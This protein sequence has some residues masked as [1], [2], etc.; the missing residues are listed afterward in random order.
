[1]NN[2]C[3]IIILVFI[4]IVNRKYLS[5][6]KYN[7]QQILQITSTFDKRINEE[8]HILSYNFKINKTIK[9]IRKY[10]S[11]TNYDKKK[12]KNN[13]ISNKSCKVLSNFKIK[14]KKILI[15]IHSHIS[16]FYQRHV[17]RKIYKIYKNI[18]LLFFI[19]LDYNI[20]LNLIV[21][22]EMNIYKDIILFNFYSNYY[23]LEYLTFNFILWL[24]RYY[25][26]YDII[27]K[28]DTDTFLNI[29][30][31]EKV[32]KRIASNTNYVIGY[33]WYYKNLKKQFP[34]G[35]CYIFSS[36]SVI[37]LAE[38]IDKLYNKNNY[39]SAEDVFFGDLSRE[40]NFI[41]YDTFYDFHYKSFLQIP[42]NITDMNNIFMIHSLRISEIAFLNY[43][44]T[45]Y[46]TNT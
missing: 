42:E 16:L 46:T 37:K 32:I 26:L 21:K 24:K 15:A 5:T 41:F 8:L 44:I 1:M 2:I 13:K 12:K 30:L 19:G 14:Y 10:L 28:Q 38:N 33:I 17:L 45:N 40:A 39:G 22:E 27:I 29:I 7:N 34:S 31:L 36:N 9:F 25:Y 11:V 4:L 43:I 18:Q 23:N 3:I 35:M 6:E 20:T